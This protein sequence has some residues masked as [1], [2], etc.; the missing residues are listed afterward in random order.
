MVMQH[1]VIRYPADDSNN[2]SSSS[3]LISRGFDEEDIVVCYESGVDVSTRSATRDTSN[4]TRGDFDLDNT[5]QTVNTLNSILDD[6]SKDGEEDDDDD[7]NDDDCGYEKN[8][9]SILF[10]DLQHHHPSN[11]AA[12][13]TVSS[14]SSKADNSMKSKKAK[15]NNSH[16]NSSE[17]KSIMGGLTFYSMTHSFVDSLC[18]STACVV[19]LSNTKSDAVYSDSKFNNRQSQ[20]RQQQG[21]TNSSSNPTMDALSVDVWQLLGCAASPG[22]AELE[23]IWSL[24]AGEMLQANN[25]NNISSSGEKKPRAARASIKRRLKRIHGLRMERVSG[26]SRHGVTI[27]STR[28]SN[29]N[30]NNRKRNTT[31]AENNKIGDDLFS[32]PVFL[33]KAFSMLDDPLASIIGQGIEPIPIQNDDDYDDDYADGYDSD[34]ELNNRSFTNPPR[35]SHPQPTL[36]QHEVM[37]SEPIPFDETEMRQ[38]VQVRSRVC[39]S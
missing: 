31:A 7:D 5:R 30:S 4:T 17:K 34:P 33:E 2:T 28:P 29:S 9:R 39:L 38:S 26:A 13:A 11:S 36:E 16:S 3:F 21:T 37:V 6:F 35:P 14:P 10:D 19:E 20:S 22:D 24:K 1:D 15:N 23:E 8:D 27:T 12:T 25:N 32:Q 18:T